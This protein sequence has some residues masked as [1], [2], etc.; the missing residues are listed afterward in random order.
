[1]NFEAEFRYQGFGADAIGGFLKLN[2]W[3]THYISR[4]SSLVPQEQH[5]VDIAMR[6]SKYSNSIGVKKRE[7]EENRS[8][9]RSES[10]TASALGTTI[11]PNGGIQG[12]TCR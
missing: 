7:S 4:L 5:S 8:V 9:L 3:V 2:F 6:S 1:M 11:G 10:Q 12:R